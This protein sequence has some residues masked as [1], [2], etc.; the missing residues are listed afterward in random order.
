MKKNYVSSFFLMAN[1]LK[2]KKA[3]FSFSIALD[4]LLCRLNKRMHLQII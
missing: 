2:A 3:F 1:Y 4:L